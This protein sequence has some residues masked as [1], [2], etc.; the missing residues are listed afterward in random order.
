VV[1]GHVGRAVNGDKHIRTARKVFG[2]IAGKIDDATVA[3]ASKRHNHNH[4]HNHNQFQP[5]HRSPRKDV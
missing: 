5:S 2:H 4:N 1:E 3:H